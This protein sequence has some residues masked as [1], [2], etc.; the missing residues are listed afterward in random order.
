MQRIPPDLPAKGRHKGLIAFIGEA[1]GNDEMLKGRPFV[2]PSGRIFNALL[3]TAGINREDH[4]ITNVFDTK[5]PGN[6]V[7]NWCAPAPEAERGGFKTLPPL[8]SA[9]FLRPEY[10]HHLDRLKQELQEWQPTVIVPLG[11]TALW[12]L[13]G[14]SGISSMRGGVQTAISILPGSKLLPTFHPSLV[15]QQWKMY[16]VVVGDL[17]KAAREAMR[18]PAIIYPN[19]ELLIDPDLSDLARTLPA[20]LSSELL[21]VDIETGW[22]QITSVGFAWDDSHAL[23]VPFLDIRRTD[24]NYWPDAAS[25]VAAWKFIR[26]VMEAP[27]P[28]LGQNFGA[29]D[30]YWFLR[31]YR[32]K[33]M[34]YTDDTRLLHH[35]LYPELPKDLE[36]MGASYTQQGPWKYWGRKAQRDKRDD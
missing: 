3:R 29:Y 34:N 18:G 23:V 30:G 2:G 26:D 8:G 16:P 7:G 14:V 28:K 31:R 5:L 36:F 35:A 27:V 32:I 19:K 20:I 24:R 17:M 25:E 11:G 13:T 1:P 12:S 15:M 6:D 33:P 21:S 4:L 22:G 10:H 9:G